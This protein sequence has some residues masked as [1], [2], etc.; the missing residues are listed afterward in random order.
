MN[1]TDSPLHRFHRFLVETLRDR[2]P[3]ALERPFTVAEIYQDLV[4]YRRYRDRIGVEMNGDYEHLLLRLLAGEGEFVRLESEPALKAIRKELE[5]ANPNTGV[6]RD[7]AAADARLLDTRV[8]D[9][10]EEEQDEADTDAQGTEA[11]DGQPVLSLHREGARGGTPRS[12]RAPSTGAEA[13][14]GA[15][16]WC[17]QALPERSDLRYC[18]RCG[19]DVRVTPCAACEAP[20]EPGWLFCVACGHEVVEV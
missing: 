11:E 16:P 13:V 12:A 18:P 15:C 1:A 14:V 4:P 8:P 5:Q 17:E 20:L 10:W 3:A 19:A 6:Y 7:Y 9:G 2:D